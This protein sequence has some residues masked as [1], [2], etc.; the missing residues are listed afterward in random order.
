MEL[1]THYLILRIYRSQAFFC[2]YNKNHKATELQQ[3]SLVSSIFRYFRQQWRACDWIRC[4][5]HDQGSQQHVGDC[6]ILQLLVCTLLI[7][8]GLSHMDQPMKTPHPTENYIFPWLLEIYS[9]KLRTI[10]CSD[11]PKN[12]LGKTAHNL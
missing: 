2:S 9:P 12:I 5:H 6:S 1:N 10:A 4:S 11:C 7:I 8:S 3:I